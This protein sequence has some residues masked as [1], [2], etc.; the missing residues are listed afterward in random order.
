LVIFFFFSKSLR[1]K[2][3]PN[4]PEED[5]PCPSAVFLVGHVLILKAVLWRRFGSDFKMRAANRSGSGDHCTPSPLSSRHSS[6]DSLHRSLMGMG[7]L[8]G[9]SYGMVGAYQSGYG[10][11]LMMSTSS[12]AM[13]ALTASPNSSAAAAAAAA[14]AA[15]KKKGIKSSLGRFF[16]KK[17]KVRLDQRAVTNSL[18]ADQSADA[19][20]K[21]APLC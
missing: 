19:L 20:A 16:S 6:Q 5:L 8:G 14:A 4:C 2:I 13:N 18:T 12:G 11:G 10:S 3:F 17:E 9:S 1:A 15:H 21:L 7:S